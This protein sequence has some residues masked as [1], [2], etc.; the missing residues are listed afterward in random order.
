MRKS[1][2]PTASFLLAAMLGLTS[3]SKQS[4][5]TTPER[6]PAVAV[7]LQTVEKKSRPATEEVVG[8]VRARLRSVIEAKV[9]GKIDRMLVVPGQNVKTSE[10]LASIEAREVQARLDQALAVRQQADADLKRF[11]ALLEQKILAQAEYDAAQSKFRVADGAVREAETLLGYTQVTAP[12]DGVITRKHADVGD[13]ATPGKPLLEMEDARSLRLEADVPEA[14]IG[15]VVL[16]AKLPVRIAALETEVE[17]L[18]SEISP[19]AD[20]GSRTFLVKLD[21]PPQPGLR[22][23]QFGRVAMPVGET[24]ALRVP[25]SAVIQRGQMEIVFVV[26]ESQ[27]QLRLVKTG[28]RIGSEVELVSGLEAGEK[29]VVEVPAGLTDG[30]PVTMP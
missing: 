22:A 23:G 16:G 12:F 27:A 20:P 19:A 30:Q 5:P 2:L 11:A 13:L 24:T 7:R 25:A 15:R 4:E 21:L 10:L 1:S 18:V 26:N 9:S 6:L 28:K 3:C 8:T 14:V 29:I 17:G